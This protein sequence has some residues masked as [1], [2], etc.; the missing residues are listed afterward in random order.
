[1]YIIFNKILF[2]I[3]SL[4]YHVLYTIMLNLYIIFN[5]NQ[6]VNIYI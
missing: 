4:K 2:K 1:M 5:D 3:L 6:F